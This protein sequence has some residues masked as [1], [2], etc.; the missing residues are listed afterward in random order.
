MPK[1]SLK[2]DTQ[3]TT[4]AFREL[5]ESTV[6]ELC[7]N[8]DAYELHDLRSWTKKFR[9]CLAMVANYRGGDLENTVVAD[10]SYEDE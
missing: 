9:N 4:E 3:L 1:I 7:E 10:A 2:R 5:A 6:A 8:C